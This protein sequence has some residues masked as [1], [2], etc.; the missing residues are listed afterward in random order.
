MLRGFQSLTQHFRRF[1][2]C[3]PSPLFPITANLQIPIFNSLVF[4]PSNY[5][6]KSRIPS[7]NKPFDKWRI[8]KGDK[9]TNDLKKYTEE[10][11]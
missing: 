6:G 10:Q 7:K 2:L 9:V 11:K 8:L 5:F 4:R 1:N 3:N